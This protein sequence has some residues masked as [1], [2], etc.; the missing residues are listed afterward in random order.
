MD[1]KITLPIKI[2]VQG[3]ELELE[4]LTRELENLFDDYGQI[5]AVYVSRK[6]EPL[7]INSELTITFNSYKRFTE[8]LKLAGGK[9]IKE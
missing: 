7:T 5:S 9:I 6:E 3:Q 4:S 2:E 8:Q 1:N